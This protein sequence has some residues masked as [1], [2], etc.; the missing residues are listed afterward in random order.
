MFVANIEHGLPLG[1]RDIPF[2]EYLIGR[3]QNEYRMSHGGK[4]ICWKWP[5]DQIKTR[6]SPKLV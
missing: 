4:M 1:D 2:R 5:K 6:T 3:T